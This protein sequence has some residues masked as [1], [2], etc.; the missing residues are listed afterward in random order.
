ME[1]ATAETEGSLG[2]AAARDLVTHVGDPERHHQPRYQFLHADAEPHP[3][4]DR[5]LRIHKRPSQFKVPTQTSIASIRR[6]NNRNRRRRETTGI[7]PRE[8]GGFGKVEGAGTRAEEDTGAV[9]EETAL[10]KGFFFDYYVVSETTSKRRGSAV[11][12]GVVVEVA[13]A[14]DA[15]LLL[16]SRG[17]PQTKEQAAHHY[18][19]S[20]CYAN[21]A[22]GVPPSRMFEVEER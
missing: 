10:G 9:D 7:L 5:R 6:E 4:L 2:R 1:S 16:L 19:S 17:P 11:E 21:A 8:E 14:G 20:Y 3:F 15:G 13:G 12:F 22:V 18:A